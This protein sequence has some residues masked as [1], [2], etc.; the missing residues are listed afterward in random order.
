MEAFQTEFFGNDFS[1]IS[2]AE[3][4]NGLLK[5]PAHCISNHK[6]IVTDELCRKVSDEK[7]D[8]DFQ[9]S[10][11]RGRVEVTRLEAKD[12]KKIRDQGQRPR[13]QRASVLYKKGL[14]KFSARSLT[15]SKSKKMVMTLVHFQQIKK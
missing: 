13:T 1:L 6:K 9:E 10:H 4:Y 2:N 3:T 12:I 15:C 7:Y 11:I 8:I 14:H 5:H